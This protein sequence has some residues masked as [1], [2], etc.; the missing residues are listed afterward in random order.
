MEICDRVEAIHSVTHVEGRAHCDAEIDAFDR[1]GVHIRE[2]LLGHVQS[3]GQ[4]QSKLPRCTTRSSP[5]VLRHRLAESAMD[6]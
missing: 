5:A 1:V 3:S 6:C 2:H 4:A